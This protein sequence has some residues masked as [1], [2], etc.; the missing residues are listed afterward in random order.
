V[1]EGG[2]HTDN[3][4]GGISYKVVIFGKKKENGGQ[5]ILAYLIIAQLLYLHTGDGE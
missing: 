3:F 1:G 4:G 5:Q 2:Q